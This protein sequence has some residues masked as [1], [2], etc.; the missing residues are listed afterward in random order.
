MKKILFVGGSLNQSSIAHAVARELEG[1]YE[2][3]FSSYYV[4]GFYS[5]LKKLG[6]LEFT[7]VGGNQLRRTMKYFTENNLPMDQAGASHDYDL[8]VFVQDILLPGNTKGKPLLLIQEGMTDREGFAYRLV[9]WFKLPLY[10]AGTAATGLSDRYQTFCVASEGYKNL[11]VSKG[12][13]PE[14]IVVTGLPNFDNA[15]QYYEND[16]PHK[17]YVMV[18]TSDSRE[19]FKRKNKKKF[20]EWTKEIAKDRPIIFK[21]HPNENVERSSEEIRA[22]LPDATI[23]TDGNTEQMIANSQALITE[24]STC[25]Y[26]GLAL[27]KESYSDYFDIEF[28]KELMPIQNRGESGKRIA[29]E[30]RKILEEN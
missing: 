10:L 13:K 3:Y 16:F 26:V 14:K 22:I 30:C 9:K 11:F 7:V 25:I 1:E 23:M 29:A 17:D 15:V 4:D 12:A 21:L 6:L 28:L 19:T 2:Y 18:A 8:F 24:Y 27:E 20:L 5:I